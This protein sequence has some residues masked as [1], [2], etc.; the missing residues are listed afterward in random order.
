MRTGMTPA[1]VLVIDD[2]PNI[3]GLVAKLLGRGHLRLPQNGDGAY[4]GMNS[5]GVEPGESCAF[6]RGV[7]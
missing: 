4:V 1:R 5:V 3:R 2:D 6:T 7:G